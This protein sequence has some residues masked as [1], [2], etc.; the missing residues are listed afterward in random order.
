MPNMSASCMA[1]CS[2][3][4]YKASLATKGYTT[5]DMVTYS[6]QRYS[7]NDIAAMCE[8]S[9]ERHYAEFATAPKRLNG[10]P[11]PGMKAKF[12]RAVANDVATSSQISWGTVAFALI[13]GMF[14]GPW[15]LVLAICTALFEY[16]M[17]K[18]MEHD[19]Q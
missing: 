1:I 3:A 7:H 11:K 6:G 15:A 12:R 2:S 10:K 8:D 4:P 5:N 18:D 17:L 9:Y 13:L 19:I 16:M 14:L